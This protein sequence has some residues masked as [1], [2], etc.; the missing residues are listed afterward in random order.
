[1][2]HRQ[3][4]STFQLLQAR[5]RQ[6][7]I[8]AS[9]LPVRVF[10]ESV[11]RLR[12]E[13]RLQA[14]RGCVNTIAWDEAGEFLCSGS[15]DMHVCVWRF[16]DRSLRLRFP[17]GHTANIFGSRFLPNSSLVVTCAGDGQA[18]VVDIAAERRLHCFQVSPLDRAK[19]VAV[20][21]GNP[22][23]FWVCAEDGLVR[24]YDLRAQHVEPE[25]VVRFM[26]GPVASRPRG[27]NSLSVAAYRPDYIAV[28]GDAPCIWVVDRRC[29]GNDGT[30]GLAARFVAPG[31]GGVEGVDRV[32]GVSLDFDGSRA[33]ASYSGGHVYVFDVR[34]GVSQLVQPVRLSG[35]DDMGEH[36][37]LDQCKP[38]EQGESGSQA[39]ETTSSSSAQGLEFP[40]DVSP[41]SVLEDPTEGLAPERRL[42]SGSGDGSDTQSRNGSRRKRPRLAGDE[43]DLIARCGGHL[44]ARTVKDVQFVGPGHN[45]VASG[46]DDGRLFIWRCARTLAVDGRPHTGVVAFAGRADEHIVNCVVSHPCE[47][48]LA[49]SGIDNDVKLLGPA[50]HM[51][52]DTAV[53][54]ELEHIMDE[55]ESQRLGNVERLAQSEVLFMLRAFGNRHLSGDD[56]GSDEDDGARPEDCRQQ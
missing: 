44:N 13:Q 35:D 26:P 9:R 33:A 50:S 19:K 24:L 12:V 46:S 49:V 15:D 39:L 56:E 52:G 32:T 2:S 10:D 21:R 54:D 20:E 29:T 48:L 17:T 40:T 47:P 55:N 51:P 14:H 8:V 1:M 22:H 18:R 45:F 11:P 36:G 37:A 43:S 3:V 7:A 5:Q 30:Y 28:G 31:V 23:C 27:L 25:T 16:Q 38:A 42:S 34:G 6:P 41:A 53:G 4:L